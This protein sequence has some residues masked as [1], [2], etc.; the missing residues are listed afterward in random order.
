M[1]T[2]SPNPATN[3]SPDQGGASLDDLE[4]YLQSKY[5]QSKSRD[6]RRIAEFLHDYQLFRLEEFKFFHS[7]VWLYVVQPTERASS[8]QKRLYQAETPTLH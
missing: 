8:I 5:L 1:A 3:D 6:D 7:M 4:E 2:S